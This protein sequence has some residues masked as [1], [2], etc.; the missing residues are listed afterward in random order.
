MTWNEKLKELERLQKS[1]WAHEDQ[2]KYLLN[3][4]ASMPSKKT[5]ERIK[6]LEEQIKEISKMKEQ[7]QQ[8]MFKMDE[9]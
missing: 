1:L 3:C 2:L 7:H 6:E 5:E 4:C 8:N 9:E